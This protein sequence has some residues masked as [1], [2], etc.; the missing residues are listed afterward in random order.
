M[1]KRGVAC[2]KV[3]TYVIVHVLVTTLVWVFVRIAQLLSLSFVKGIA[4]PSRDSKLKLFLNL[5]A[6]HGPKFSCLFSLARSIYID[7]T[8]SACQ[9][10]KAKN[11][12]L[13]KLDGTKSQLF[14]FMKRGRPLVVNFGSCS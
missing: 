3:M 1:A 9:S 12:N 14:D 13:I 8:K 5:Y 6:I 4:T 11:V 7:T 10:G 2:L